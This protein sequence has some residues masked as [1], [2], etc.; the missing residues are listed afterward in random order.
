MTADPAPMTAPLDR[1]RAPLGARL[2]GL[3]LNY[4]VLLLLLVVVVALAVV[5][6]N[7]FSAANLSNLPGQWAPVGVLAIAATMVIIAG[8]FDMSLGATFAFAAVVAAGV[9]TIAP[10]GVAYLAALGVGAVVGVLNGLIVQYGGINPFVATLGTSFIVTGI[11]FT[12]TN[13]QPFYIYG[14]AFAFLGS[15]RTLGIPNSGWVLILLLVLAGLVMWKTVFGRSLYAIGGNKEAA[16]L[17][18]IRVGP[19]TM[20][21]Y[22]LSGLAAGVAGILSASTLGSGQMTSDISVLF[23]AI[24]VVLIGGTS[25]AGGSGAIWRTAIGLAILACLGNGFN[26]LNLSS[27]LQ[28]IITGVIVLAALG[29]DRVLV[30][31][32]RSGGAAA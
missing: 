22:I 29:L 19:I 4:A 2:V 1:P 11:G 24:T 13:A 12:V 27:Y 15:G 26:Q 3:S 6:P 31:G 8:G 7:F 14:T 21:T 23:N 20:T 25:L 28:S 17:A 16:R 5:S 32:R 9:G 30:R 18:G 10:P